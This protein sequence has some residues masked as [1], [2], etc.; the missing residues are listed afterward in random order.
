MLGPKVRTDGDE[1]HGTTQLQLHLLDLQSE[2]LVPPA[3]DRSRGSCPFVLS[4]RRPML[5]KLVQEW[6]PVIDWQTCKDIQV[7]YG[8]RTWL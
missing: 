8:Y 4:L 5:L 1:S 7:V 6:L 2:Y 3:W